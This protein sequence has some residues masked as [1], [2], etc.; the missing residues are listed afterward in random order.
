[1]LADVLT[2]FFHAL[3]GTAV[4]RMAERTALAYK[5]GAIGWPSGGLPGRGLEIALDASSA[6]SFLQQVV[7]DKFSARRQPPTT[8]CWAT[9]PSDFARKPTL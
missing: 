5:V 6:F 8:R 3:E 9:S 4:E 2:G 7:F 1:M